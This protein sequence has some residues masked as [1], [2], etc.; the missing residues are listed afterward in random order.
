ML[1]AYW[2]EQCGICSES[3]NETMKTVVFWPGL[4]PGSSERFRRVGTTWI[5]SFKG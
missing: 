5:H 3:R 4:E 2:K 1:A